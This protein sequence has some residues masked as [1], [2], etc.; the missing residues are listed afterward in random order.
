MVLVL[1]VRFSFVEEEYPLWN[2]FDYA[3]DFLFTVDIFLNFNTA[4][5]NDNEELVDS[6]WKIAKNYL[7]FW[8]WVDSIS[9]LPLHLVI[10]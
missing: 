4:F 6:R 3:I 9:I 2:Y 1:P 5:Y 7:K 10:Q 8:F